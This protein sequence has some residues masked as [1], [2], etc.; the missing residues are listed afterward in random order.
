[1]PAAIRIAGADGDA[2]M[3][4]RQSDLRGPLAIVVGSEGQGLGAVIRR[5]CDLFMRIPMR[6]AVG[7][8]NAAVAG[9]ILL[10][11]AVAQRD[12]SSTGDGGEA[13]VAA[14]E[15]VSRGRRGRHPRDRAWDRPRI[16][17]PVPIDREA[18][19]AL[20]GR[21]DDEGRQVEQGAKAPREAKAA[22]PAPIETPSSAKA[23][24]TRAPKPKA[25]KAAKAATATKSAKTVQAGKAPKAT[26]VTKAPK[27]TRTSKGASPASPDAAG[28]ESADDDLLPAGG[29][30]PP[31]TSRPARTP[32]AR[33][34]SGK[35]APPDP[36]A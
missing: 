21:E 34:A 5:R 16:G 14:P 36:H 33:R 30:V 1:M 11:E 18:G 27:A 23:V 32:R 12:P 4:A 22:E 31:T 10:F 13:A 25:A 2:P 19:E 20:E 29:A 17:S 28:S 6:G 15:A 8:L 3:T 35:E 26:T 9:S 24:A 7:S